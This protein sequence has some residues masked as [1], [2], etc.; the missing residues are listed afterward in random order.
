VVNSQKGSVAK[1]GILS[2]II[3]HGQTIDFMLSAK[4]G[5]R[6]AKRFSRKMLKATQD[7]SP[8]VIT[9]DKNPAYPPAV[10][11]L[12]P[13]GLLSKNCGLRQCRYL[14]NVVGQDRRFIKWRV[15]PRPGFFSFKTARRTIKGY[16]AMHMI[17]KG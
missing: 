17:R 15:N 4:R 8:R 10:E 9:V 3:K 2:S 6:A 11:E 13:D 7:Q 1:T 14:N 5:A 12:K 16:E